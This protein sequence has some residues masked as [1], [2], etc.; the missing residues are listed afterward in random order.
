[1]QARAALS[2]QMRRAATGAG[3]IALEFFNRD[4]E[5]WE[6]TSAKGRKSPVSEADLA[7]NAYLK[8]HLHEE[9]DV[10]GWLSEETEDDRS[11]FDKTHVWMVDP[12]DGTRAFLKGLP[13]FTVC[14]A[15][16]E[17]DRPILG[18]VFNPATDELFFA[19][20]GKGATLND[21]P[22]RA[23]TP[24]VL[25][26]CRMVGD[27]DHFKHPAWPRPWPPMHVER[28]NSMA[29]SIALVA[30]GEF[31]AT[32]AFSS[33]NDWDLAAAGLIAEEAGALM[34]THKGEPITFNLE[35]PHH[36]SVLCAGAKLHEALLERTRHLTLPYRR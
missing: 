24:D 2:E 36:P 18:V 10:F 22:I 3:K 23:S 34:T 33:R 12:I 27:P 1:M 30:K 16:M 21:A 14:V 11:R 35:N 20:A 32:V 26:G 19:E 29:Y 25:E 6:K 8:T 5:I 13:H 15:L 17:M 7:V 4:Q 28:R 9:T 31:D